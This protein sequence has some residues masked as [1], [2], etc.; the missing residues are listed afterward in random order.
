MLPLKPIGENPSLPLPSFWWQHRFGLQLHPSSFCSIVPW[1][2]PGISVS[3]CSIFLFL[4]GNQSYWITAPP[5]VHSLSIPAGTLFPISS[6]SEVLGGRTLTWF[7]RGHNSTHNKFLSSSSES[8][9]GRP[10]V[11]MTLYSLFPYIFLLFCFGDVS[12]AAT[13]VNMLLQNTSKPAKKHQGDSAHR[14]RQHLLGAT[15]AWCSGLCPLWS[16]HRLVCC[17]QSESSHVPHCDLTYS[18]LHFALSISSI[19]LPKLSW[20][21]G[22]SQ[23]QLLFG[24]KTSLSLTL[25][26][27]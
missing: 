2:S 19:L 12:H 4:Q 20:A 14:R 8:A 23:W 1:C 5:K 13:K 6:H 10:W 15:A 24:I 25:T 26:L 21:G 16:S 3:S 7:S 18:T 11:V 17:V 9:H 22:Q 27:N